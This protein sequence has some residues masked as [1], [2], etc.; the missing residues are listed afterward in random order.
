VIA[1]DAGMEVTEIL[2]PVNKDEQKNLAETEISAG[3][4]VR[5]VLIPSLEESMPEGQII[6][7]DEEIP[8]KHANR[9][10]PEITAEQSTPAGQRTPEE[11][12]IPIKH[13]NREELKIPAERSTPGGQ[14][15]KIE[16][17]N[18]IEHL[19]RKYKGFA[20]VPDI[21]VKPGSPVRQVTQ[22]E[23]EILYGPE[24]IIGVRI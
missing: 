20:E 2:L 11:P 4:S 8:K 12:K 3:Q 6:S 13:S 16:P 19:N 18:S 15:N 24:I 1:D 17:E 9:E 14:H 7:A 23:P 21:P 10:E 22:A 5:A